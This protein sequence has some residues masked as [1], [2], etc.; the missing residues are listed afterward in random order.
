[1]AVF[2]AASDGA[3]NVSTPNRLG[4]F[5]G[6]TTFASLQA[7]RVLN[8]NKNQAEAWDTGFHQQANQVWQHVVAVF[9]PVSGSSK[10][11]KLY[12]DGK[13]VSEADSD[14]VLSN[15]LGTNSVLQ[16]GKGN[17]GSG[18]YYKGYLDEY[19]IYNRALTSAEVAQLHKEYVPLA[20]TE[21][22]NIVDINAKVRLYDYHGP[23]DKAGVGVTERFGINSQNL[24]ANG[25]LFY[26][27]T[28]GG[29]PAVDGFPW[30]VIGEHERNNPTM[31]PVLN[32]NGYPEGTLIGA[33][34]YLFD[35]SERKV[36]SDRS[37]LVADHTPCYC[38][39]SGML[40][41]CIQT[42]KE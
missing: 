39:Y 15:I 19:K 32:S 27:N 33:M 41:R 1:M 29:G 38:R 25:Y 30:D 5:C 34:D 37:A 12:V 23:A 13:L 4:V 20:I 42:H 8:D 6:N 3:G 17:F 11:I 7:E 26:N 9:E 35:T 22:T 14:H 2:V 24:G 21:D 40:G 18:E 10:E 36:T 28:G 31:Q 16:I